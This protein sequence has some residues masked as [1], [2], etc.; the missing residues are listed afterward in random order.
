MSSIVDYN[1]DS[2]LRYNRL[3]NT[4]ATML[5]DFTRNAIYKRT[6]CLDKFGYACYGKV[7]DSCPTPYKSNITPADNRCNNKENSYSDQKTSPPVFMDKFYNVIDPVETRYDIDIDN[8]DIRNMTK[9]AYYYA[10][11]TEQSRTTTAS[12]LTNGLKGPIEFILGSKSDPEQTVHY[13][14]TDNWIT[15]NEFI[16][17]RQDGQHVYVTLRIHQANY[18]GGEVVVQA[19]SIEKGKYRSGITKHSFIITGYNSI[20]VKPEN[21]TLTPYYIE[22]LSN[23]FDVDPNDNNKLYAPMSGDEVGTSWNNISLTETDKELLAN[24]IAWLNAYSYNGPT[25]ANRDKVAIGFKEPGVQLNKANTYTYGKSPLIST[26]NGATLDDF[27]S[28]ASKSWLQGTMKWNSDASI[29]GSAEYRIATMYTPDKVDFRMNGNDIEMKTFG[30][31]KFIKLIGLTNMTTVEVLDARTELFAYPGFTMTFN[32]AGGAS[33]NGGVG[34]VGLTSTNPGGVQS[35][36]WRKIASLLNTTQQVFYHHMTKVHT[37]NGTITDSNGNGVAITYEVDT[38]RASDTITKT[39]IAKSTFTGE[40]FNGDLTD[41]QKI[42]NAGVLGFNYNNTYTLANGSTLQGTS[43]PI[44][45]NVIS[46]EET[47]VMGLSKRFAWAIVGY[48][49]PETK[50]SMDINQFLFNDPAY[51][52]RGIRLDNNLVMDGI[53]PPGKEPWETMERNY[54]GYGYNE[55]RGNTTKPQ[56]FIGYISYAFNIPGIKVSSDFVGYKLIRNMKVNTTSV[57]FSIEYTIRGSFHDALAD[58]VNWYVSFA[59]VKPATG[60]ET[61][62]ATNIFNIENGSSG[63]W[64]D[65]DTMLDNGYTTQSVYFYVPQSFPTTTTQSTLK[66][67]QYHPDGKGVILDVTGRETDY[68]NSTTRTREKQDVVTP[69]YM[70]SP[71]DHTL[72]GTGVRKIPVSST[73]QQ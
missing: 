71:S 14:T 9:T 62:F 36:G 35:D 25:S 23:W 61:N 38:Y 55:F 27:I 34:S 48:M 60:L 10:I 20:T 54:F 33:A 42:T 16:D 70:K 18:S 8:L 64:I 67:F 59:T 28:S 30:S 12:S 46:V 31:F 56:G 2:K 53:P 58:N 6:G 52:L 19:Y 50:L 69:E 17:R 57:Y 1:K 73:M 40:W 41:A 65:E 26:L 11:T 22:Y 51:G 32:E 43:I 13:W 7:D 47:F 21:N 5:N 72:L 66:L 15:T 3:Y 44:G 63:I 4:K 29:T 49:M 37:V 24:Y 39:Y 45:V 68:Y